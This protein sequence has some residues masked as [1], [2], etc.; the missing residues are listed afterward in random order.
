MKNILIEVFSSRLFQIGGLGCLFFV[1]GIYFYVQWD[2]ARFEASLPKA[3]QQDI[4]IDTKDVTGTR[5]TQAP[6]NAD[7]PSVSTVPGPRARGL[8]T[9]THTDGHIHTHA[10]PPPATNGTQQTE[11]TDKWVVMW[12]PDIPGL[13]VHPK[14]PDP[15]QFPIEVLSEVGDIGWALRDGDI[16]QEESDQKELEILTKYWGVDIDDTEGILGKMEEYNYVSDALLKHM[17]PERAFQTLFDWWNTRTVRGIDSDMLDAYAARALSVNPNN[18]DARFCLGK[19][20]ADFHA[21]LD[22]DPNYYPAMDVIARLRYHDA[23]EEVIPLLQKSRDLGSKAANMLLGWTYERLG[24]YKTAWTHYYKSLV[25]QPDGQV[26]LMHMGAIFRGEPRIEP[27]QRRKQTLPPAH[28]AF[29][30]QPDRDTDIATDGQPST[31]TDTDWRPTLN[32]TDTAEAAY[33]AKAEAAKKASQEFQ[34]LQNQSQKEFA[35]FIEWL[36]HGINDAPDAQ[37]FLSQQMKAFLRQEKGAKATPFAPE[38]IIRAQEML[39]RYGPEEGLKRL[40]QDDPEIAEHTRRTP[41]MSCD[42]R[43]K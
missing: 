27:I 5:T 1:V 20:T 37:D 32:E 24:D 8:E 28:G 43:D 19:T 29:D 21:I 11:A 9:H 25:Q 14:R 35:E 12:P 36:E 16:S 4:Q 17:E 39:E 18:I 23:P 26:P 6:Q 22:V 30:A 3:P 7:V 34:K 38:R 33:N 2:T 13:G 42:K 31:D 41:P 15:P 40:E 10:H